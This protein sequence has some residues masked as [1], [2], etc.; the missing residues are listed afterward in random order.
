MAH[1]RPSAA[2][3]SA[4]RARRAV[5][6]ARSFVS[7]GSA[8]KSKSRQRTPVRD[9]LVHELV[10]CTYRRAVLRGADDALVL[11]ID[12]DAIALEMRERGHRGI[13]DAVLRDGGGRPE[14]LARLDEVHARCR[15][16]AAPPCRSAVRSGWPSMIES[17]WRPTELGDRRVDV[18]QRHV[19]LLDRGL[20]FG[21]R[22]RRDSRIAERHPQR[23]HPAEVVAVADALGALV[24]ALAVIG[25]EHDDRVVE[26]SG[27]CASS[28]RSLPMAASRLGERGAVEG[29]DLPSVHVGRDRARRS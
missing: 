21:E 18:E 12:G 29:V 17:C 22:A 2:P 3:P 10:G 25:G 11:R 4:P 14:P 19:V 23:H 6:A 9:G 5:S 15:P 26:P 7:S 28:S 20:A 8:S 24:E 1:D 13:V 16:A 27:R